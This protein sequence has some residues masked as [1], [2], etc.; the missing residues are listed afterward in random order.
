MTDESSNPSDANAAKEAEGENAGGFQ[1]KEVI[2]LEIFFAVVVILILA[3][4]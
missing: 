1:T 4:K 3:L 2:A